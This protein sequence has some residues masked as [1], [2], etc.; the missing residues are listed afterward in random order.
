M[1]RLAMARAGSVAR[2][3]AAGAG[4]GRPGVLNFYPTAGNGP[5]RCQCLGA[6]WQKLAHCTGG[7]AGWGGL[8]SA[9][10][11]RPPCMRAEPLSALNACFFVRRLAGNLEYLKV[12][13]RCAIKP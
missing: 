5:R 4:A 3:R 12:A 8:Y 6:K 10:Y 9:G 2:L 13:R 11:S 1:P 7:A